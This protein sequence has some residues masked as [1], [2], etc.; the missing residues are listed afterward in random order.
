MRTLNSSD[1][2]F[3]K[4]LQ[5]EMNTQAHDCQAD[6]R[7]WVVAQDEKMVS[8]ID[9]CDGCILINNE[10]TEIG[11][12]IEEVKEFFKDNLEQEDYDSLNLSE[13]DNDEYADLEDIARHL[14]HAYPDSGY[15]V[16]YYRNVHV[17]KENTFFLTK[18]ECKEHIKANYYHYNKTVH[19]YAM[20]AWRSPQVEKLYEIIKNADLSGLLKGG[21]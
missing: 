6:P 8:N 12:T 3:L 16:W 2:E 10:G 9:Y 5:E 20:T 1:I 11:E 18:R 17:I 7:F 15:Q 21:E 19:S 14:N 13:F 4:A